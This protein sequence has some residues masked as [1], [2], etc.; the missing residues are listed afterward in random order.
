MQAKRKY[1]EGEPNFKGLLIH[2]FQGPLAD[3][4]HPFYSSAQ[5]FIL[6]N[7]HIQSITALRTR[8]SRLDIWH[9]PAGTKPESHQVDRRDEAVPLWK[10]TIP[11][12][13]SKLMR[14]TV[15]GAL[16]NGKPKTG[17]ELNHYSKEMWQRTTQTTKGLKHM[18][19]KVYPVWKTEGWGEGDWGIFLQIFTTFGENKLFSEIAQEAQ[20][21]CNTGNSN[22]TW[23]KKNHHNGSQISEDIL[24]HIKKKQKKPP[25]LNKP[26][27]IQTCQSYSKLG[28]K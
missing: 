19:I 17:Q 21:S 18:H 10:K 1:Y 28:P 12:L 24:R 3:W 14:F 13:I 6:I 25:Y 27:A 8:A 23:E 22:Q 7:S 15:P 5:T 4:R 11:P 26:L 16:C 2:H 20:V 9:G